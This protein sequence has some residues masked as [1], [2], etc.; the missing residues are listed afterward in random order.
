MIKLVFFDF[1]DTISENHF[2][3]IER[4]QKSYAGLSPQ[5]SRYLSQLHFPEKVFV[6][7]KPVSVM[8]NA[9]YYFINEGAKIAL[10]SWCTNP[11]LM[12]LKKKFCEEHYTGL[13]DFYAFS[14]SRTDKLEWIQ[15]Y[16]AYYG[17][18]LSECLL[19][20]DDFET[21]SGARK[22]G[23]Q[24]MSIVETCNTFRK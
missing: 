19:I 20:D 9:M 23:I 7:C 14:Q 11:I 18:D 10:L 2:D 3:E 24:T 15:A 8:R 5:A 4:I 1:D 22:L 17:I 6:E 12:E 13:F 21:L 16:C